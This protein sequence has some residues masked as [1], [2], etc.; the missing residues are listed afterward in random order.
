MFDTAHDSTLADITKLVA[1]LI[2]P[3]TLLICVLSQR[4]RISRMLS[5]LVL[6]A[7]SANK[8]KIFQVEVEKTVENSIDREVQK[9]AE[10]AQPHK[11]PEIP[12][13]EALA[14]SRVETLISSLPDQPSRDNLTESV[15]VKMLALGHEYETTRASMP[16]GKDRTGAMNAVVAR[17]RTLALAAKPFLKEFSENESSPGIRLCAIVILQIS[18]D[19]RYLEWLGDRYKQ[20]TPFIF[21]Q[22]AVALM[23]AVKDIGAQNRE[24]LRRVITA[25]IAVVESFREGPPDR[26]TLTVLNSALS[27]LESLD[28]EK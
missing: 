22:T 9:A 2:W 25:A 21:Y 20:E 4:Q 1:V 3:V 12:K 16:S 8:I 6:L 27:T 7:E 23:Q 10:N 26:N 15:R 17:M 14:A 24:Q 5:A 18:P 13:L 19:R 11:T 28:P